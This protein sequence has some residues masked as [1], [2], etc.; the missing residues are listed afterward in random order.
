MGASRQARA[1]LLFATDIV[2]IAFWFH[3]LQVSFTRKAE[4]KLGSFRKLGDEELRQR[5]KDHRHTET[6]IWLAV[7]TKTRNFKLRQSKKNRVI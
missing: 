7:S 5:I 3:E 2:P 1:F 6:R 4:T